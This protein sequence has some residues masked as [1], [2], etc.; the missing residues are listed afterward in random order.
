MS[1]PASE[2]LTLPEASALLCLKVSTL[3]SW[4]GRRRIP[5]VKVGRLVRIRRSDVEALIASS[6]VPAQNSVL[7]QTL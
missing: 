2:L 1:T 7:G 6:T 3:R 5:F 4:T